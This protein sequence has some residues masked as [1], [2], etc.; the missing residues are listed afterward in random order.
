MADKK[1]TPDKK[2]VE[3]DPVITPIEKEKGPWGTNPPPK[4]T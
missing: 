3:D 4:P 2:P 1:S